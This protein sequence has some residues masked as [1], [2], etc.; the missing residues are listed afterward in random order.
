MKKL[1][2]IWI[3]FGAVTIFA[4]NYVLAEGPHH[5]MRAKS[6]FE[7]T[8]TNNDGFVSREELRAVRREMRKKREERRSQRQHGIKPS[9]VDPGETQGSSE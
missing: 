2:M 9:G 3:L 4:G 1:G 8:D 5:N 6:R 7:A